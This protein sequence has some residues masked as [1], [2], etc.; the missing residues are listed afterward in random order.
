MRQFQ[1]T[2]TP[3]N[4]AASVG[5]GDL[6]VLATPVLI[7]WCENAAFTMCSS[8]VPSDRTTVGTMVKLEHVK[9]SPVGAAVTVK[10]AEPINDGRRLVCHVTVI[11]SE[12]DEIAR[13]EVHRAVVD[14]ERFMSKCQRLV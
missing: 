13:G 10:C 8:S 9:G 5:S 11:D 3:D 6:E 4:T 12:G 1:H 2:V 14:P 7:T